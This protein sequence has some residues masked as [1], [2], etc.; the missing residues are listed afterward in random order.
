MKRPD[1]TEIKEVALVQRP[2]PSQWLP[3]VNVLDEGCQVIHH[4]MNRW[5]RWKRI[6]KIR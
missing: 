1:T 4:G 3:V 5:Y 2:K 6:Q